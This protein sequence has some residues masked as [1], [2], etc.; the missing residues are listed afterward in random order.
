VAIGIVEKDGD[1]SACIDG[2]SGN[3]VGDEFLA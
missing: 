3:V 1:V 2:G